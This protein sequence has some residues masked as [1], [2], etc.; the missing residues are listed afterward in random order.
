MEMKHA[1]ERIEAAVFDDILQQYP[2]VVPEKLGDLEKQRLDVI[3]EALKERHPAFL[4]KSELAT[5]ME[6]KL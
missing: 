4:T 1:F 3:P 5:L 2:T 6:W